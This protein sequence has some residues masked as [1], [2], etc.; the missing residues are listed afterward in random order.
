MEDIKKLD[1]TS[2]KFGSYA[3]HGDLHVSNLMGSSVAPN[4]VEKINLMKKEAVYHSTTREPLGKSMPRGVS[5]PEHMRDEDFRFGMTSAVADQN[6]K[7][8]IFPV[9][10]DD[11]DK[12]RDLYIRSHASYFPGEQRSRGYA[13][14]SKERVYGRPADGVA[15]NGASHNVRAVLNPAPEVDDVPAVARKRLEDLKNLQPML[16]K[17]RNLGQ[18]TERLPHDFTFGQASDRR[19]EGEWD[20][21]QC[22]HGAYSAEEQMP[23]ADIGK[24]LTPGFRNIAADD[25]TFGLPSARPVNPNA[26]RSIADP[27]AYGSSSASEL[28]KPSE[29]SDMAID[30]SAFTRPRSRSEINDLFNSIGQ[31]ISPDAFDVVF[32]LASSDMPERDGRASVSAFRNRLVDYQVAEDMGE[33]EQWRQMHGL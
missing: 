16:G 19:R 6:A 24:T 12:G 13:N 20:C 32:D 22:L 26:R 15:V 29:L 11:H 23:D 3:D 8:L 28:I 10:D 4:T 2:R 33:V 1:L 17:P 9:M 21:S 25:R 30:A 14:F 27:L 18:G 31:S 7:E 5:M